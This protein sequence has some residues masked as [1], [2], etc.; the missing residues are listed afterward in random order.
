MLG[1]ALLG[2]MLGIAVAPWLVAGPWPLL[3][4]PAVAGLASRWRKLALA[5]LLVGPAAWWA[6]GHVPHLGP[7]DV[8]EL[9][10][11]R[12]TRL[13]GVV[14]QPPSGDA[15]KWHTTLT[16]E[17]AT[18][19]RGRVV[20]GQ[21]L[22]SWA[23][24]RRPMVGERWA[25]AG[26]VH[27]PGG[28]QNPGDF[29]LAGF[30]ARR[31]IYATMH[32]ESAHRLGLASAWRAAYG[33]DVWR[34]RLLAGLGCGLSASDA[35]LLG[36]L[37]Y[38]NGADPVDPAIAGAFRMVG[39]A[40][41]LAAS[42]LQL[43]LLAG[44]LYAAARKLGAPPWLAALLAVPGVV[45]YCAVTGAPPSMWRAT[46]MALMALGGQALGRRGAPCASL[47]VSAI[48]LLLSAP[49][50]VFDIGWQFSYLATYA[51]M[52]LGAWLATKPLPLPE[53]LVGAVLVPI[54]AWAW[55]TPLQAAR[56]GTWSAVALPVNWLADP[57]VMGLTPWG[58]AVSLLGVVWP[59]GAAIANR[60]TALALRLL[61][62]LVNTFAAMPASNL[63]APALG[64]ACL[65]GIY[66]ALWCGLR[67]PRWAIACLLAA[68]LAY[69]RPSAA[70][71]LELSF[72]SV[73]Q[74]DGIAIRT[75]HG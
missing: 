44:L 45:G 33:L 4:L 68:L 30:L 42:G 73:G 52:R 58:L 36:S 43:T 38:G 62:A 28:P 1:A 65:A 20:T 6:Q 50:D 12:F 55:V 49:Q 15:R 22:A 74:G 24:P 66:G 39:L 17:R 11:R 56:F 54:V 3:G 26:R 18:W 51:L 46:I 25:I 5:L 72:L 9:A 48:A 69:P 23:S 14:S 70:T 35:A 47:Y 8:S 53:R 67:H 19:P 27:R 7:H 31:G 16:V 60:L 40:H 10:Y 57:I 21:L 71:R 29:D 13:V 41:L 37:I 63:E 59:A 34:M 61:L 32:A 2:V 64:V 75:P